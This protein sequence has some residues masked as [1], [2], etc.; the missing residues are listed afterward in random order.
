MLLLFLALAAAAGLFAGQF[1]PGAWYAAL[2]KPSWNPPSWL[3]G[4]VWLALYISMA[5]AAW[6]VWQRR[7][8]VDVRMPLGFWGAQLVLNALWSWLFF[9]RH[10]MALAT[11]EILVLLLLIIVTSALFWRVRPLAG[12]LLV[13]YA[14]WIAFASLLT[15][16]LWRLNGA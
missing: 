8:A 1:E 10:Q 12:A 5:V 13:P 7:A 9:G 11:A 6:M 3:F 16:T 15:A 14:L 4:P 2:D